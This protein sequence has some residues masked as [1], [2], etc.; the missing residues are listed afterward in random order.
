MGINRVNIGFDIKDDKVDHQQLWV[1]HAKRRVNAIN[2]DHRAFHRQDL[3]CILFILCIYIY[4]YIIFMENW[5]EF[6]SA[7]QVSTHSLSAIFWDFQTRTSPCLA[8]SPII[9]HHCPP[10]WVC[11]AHLPLDNSTWLGIR[12]FFSI[13]TYYNMETHAR[14]GWFSIQVWVLR[15]YN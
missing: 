10:S 2:H 8:D 12:F 5:V 14:S 4:I 6:L 15:V 3:G 1:N 13:G 9:V 11:Y 7:K